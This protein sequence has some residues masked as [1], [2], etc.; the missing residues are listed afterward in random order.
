[1]A[2]PFTDGDGEVSRAEHISPRKTGDNIQAKRIA[3]YVW[4]GA[5]W[6]RMTQPGGSSSSSYS[7]PTD[8]YDLIQDDDT[9]SA[10]YEYYGYMKSDGGWYIKRITL[11]SNLREYVK[12]TSG[13]TAAW[14]GRA[15]LSYNP[16]ETEF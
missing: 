5:E 2:D 13:Y 14:T 11:A 7:K 9:S 4:D 6:Q 3:N 12:G 10:S 1:M 15:G 16:Y 8:E